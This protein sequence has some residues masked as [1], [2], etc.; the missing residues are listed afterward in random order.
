LL[1]AACD[2]SGPVVPVSGPNGQPGWL[3]VSCKGSPA[4]CRELAAQ[5]CPHGYEVL[6]LRGDGSRYTSSA[7]LEDQMGAPGDNGQMIIGCR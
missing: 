1:A 4:R 3:Q 6:D 7:G 2:Y 5:A